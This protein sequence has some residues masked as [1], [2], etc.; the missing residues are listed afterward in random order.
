M[1]NIV[2]ESYFESVKYYDNKI[3]EL[4][5]ESR[6]IKKKIE[7]AQKV[8][9]KIKN[10]NQA[11]SDLCDKL[12]KLSKYLRSVQINGGPYDKGTFENKAKDILE[13]EDDFDRLIRAILDKIKEL[14]QR[15]NDIAAKQFE[16]ESMKQFEINEVK[17]QKT[18][19]TNTT[20]N[21]KADNL[22]NGIKRKNRNEKLA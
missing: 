7:D 1:V 11:N 15:L 5:I 16:Y 8:Y 14:K 21:I 6:T 18:K 22:P 20:E 9:N 19:K 2:D 17:N 4:K 3:A 10:I 13:F 12:K